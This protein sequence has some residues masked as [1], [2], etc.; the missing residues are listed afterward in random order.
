MKKYKLAYS[1]LFILVIIMVFYIAYIN[2]ALYK[3]IIKYHL[4]ILPLCLIIPLYIAFKNKVYDKKPLM[5]YCSIFSVIVFITYLS[6]PTYTYQEAVE[7]VN[8][9]L[10]GEVMEMKKSFTDDERFFYKGNYFIK[11]KTDN[12]IKSIIFD[13]KSGVYNEI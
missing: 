4:S 8:K 6:L 10:K 11:I 12:Q 7:I 13:I 5:V 1:I 9:D 2:I 3:S